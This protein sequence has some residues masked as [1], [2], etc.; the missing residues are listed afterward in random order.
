MFLLSAHIAG[1]V[2]P[3]TK[4]TSTLSDWTSC[5]AAGAWVR[6]QSPSPAP[7]AAA[8]ASVLSAGIL[9]NF[10]PSCCETH[11]IAMSLPLPTWFEM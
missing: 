10:K 7:I 6:A 5:K 1:M 2:L 8:W 4:V 9:L 3:V 11:S